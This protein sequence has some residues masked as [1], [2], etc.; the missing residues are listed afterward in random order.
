MVVQIS[1]LFPPILAAGV[2]LL[3]IDPLSVLG[4]VFIFQGYNL[5]LFLVRISIL[6]LVGW[7]LAKSLCGLSL[8]ALMVLE[9]STQILTSCMDFLEKLTNSQTRVVKIY[10]ELQIWNFYM[11]QNFGYFIVPPLI[12]FGMCIIILSNYLTIRLPSIV[13][14]AFLYLTFPVTSMIGFVGLVT[15]LPQAAMIWEDSSRFLKLLRGKC[16]SRYEMRLARSLRKVAINVGPFRP[17]TKVWM[18]SILW[19][20]VNYTIDLLLTF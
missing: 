16:L 12:F 3:K 5:V 13:R 11:N 10:R 20:I 9:G 4:Q 15:I 18:T 8:M 2:V 1:P 19:K 7:E 6:T 17:V 14:V